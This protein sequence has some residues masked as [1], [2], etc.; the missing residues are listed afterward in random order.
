MHKNSITPQPRH[1]L[2]ALVLEN[3]NPKRSQSPNPKSNKYLMPVTGT[4]QHNPEIKSE[5]IYL[6]DFLNNDHSEETS[7]LS[8]RYS[9]KAKQGAVTID[10]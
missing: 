8:K 1:L 6:K 7:F 2:P 3:T 10:I 4:L 9:K 5:E